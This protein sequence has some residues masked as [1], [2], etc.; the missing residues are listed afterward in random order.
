[1]YMCVHT[2]LPGHCITSMP[3]LK[4]L[5][6]VSGFLISNHGRHNYAHPHATGMTKGKELTSCDPCSPQQGLNKAYASFE[7][8][9]SHVGKLAISLSRSHQLCS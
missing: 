5:L 3:F 1:M 8:S 7:A 2:Q 6:K 9:S 4:Y